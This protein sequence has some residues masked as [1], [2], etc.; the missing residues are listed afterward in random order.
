M[1]ETSASRSGIEAA[2]TAPKTRSEDHERRR[3]P[4]EQLALLK[5]LLG[6]LLEVGVA[7]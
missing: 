3:Q 5:I 2:T 4:E 7:S 6:E 1:I